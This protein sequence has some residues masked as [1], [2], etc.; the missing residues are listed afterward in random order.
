MTSFERNPDKADSNSFKCN[1][2]VEKPTEDNK[3]DAEKNDIF[4]FIRED[5][6]GKDKTFV[7]PYGKRRIVYCDH[8]ASSRALNS[9]ES[10]IQEYVLTSYGNTHTSTSATSAQSSLFQHEAR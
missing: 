3:D 7:S 2:V 4:E 5:I 8:I 9:I 10:Y 6:I 1:D